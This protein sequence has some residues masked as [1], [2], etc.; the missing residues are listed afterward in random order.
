[1][2]NIAGYIGDE[3]AA[4]ILLEMTERQQGFAGGYS[5]GI[6][7]I[8]DGEL[9]SAKVVGDVSTLKAGLSLKIESKS[10]HCIHSLRALST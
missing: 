9:Y 7:T 8:C 1:M 10:I 2:C 5:T 4:P 6:A 3:S